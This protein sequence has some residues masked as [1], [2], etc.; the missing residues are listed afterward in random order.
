MGTLLALLQPAVSS[1]QVISPCTSSLVMLTDLFSVA[2]VILLQKH[3]AS[4]GMGSE[5][6]MPIF[7]Y[8]QACV[9]FTETFIQL[10]EP[11]PSSAS[12][13]GRLNST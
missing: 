5:T 7:S 12:C 1:V 3:H 9:Y 11:K 10:R 2:A 13:C 8:W 6:E 4:Q